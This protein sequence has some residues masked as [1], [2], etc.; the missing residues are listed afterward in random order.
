[1][2][3]QECA[4]CG[5]HLAPGEVYVCTRCTDSYSE[6]WTL[7]V[8]EIDEILLITGIEDDEEENLQNVW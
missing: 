1:M 6:L 7:P 8:P 2:N 4:D 5:A 3:G